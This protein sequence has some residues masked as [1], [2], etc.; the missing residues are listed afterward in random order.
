MMAFLWGCYYQIQE[1]M[2]IGGIILTL[3][4]LPY[5]LPRKWGMALYITAFFYNPWYQAIYYTSFV[6]ICYV[7]STTAIGGLRVIYHNMV[8]LKQ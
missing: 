8:L 5:I 1:L 6:I 7:V 4:G 2:H 3:M